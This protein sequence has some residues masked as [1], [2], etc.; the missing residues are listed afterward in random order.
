MAI[1]LVT[2][3]GA[4]RRHAR[5]RTGR[6]GRVLF[7]TDAWRPQVNG[8]VRTLSK[9]A[10]ALPALG[11]EPVFLSP[12]GFRTIPLPGYPGIRLALP[13]PSRVKRAMAEAGADHVHIVTEGPLGQLARRQ[14]LK[15]GRRF[16]SNYHTKFP[17][18]L[19]ARAPIP[20]ALTYALLRRFHNAAAATLVATQSLRD[21][22][23]AKGF[24][25]IRPWTRCVD[26]EQFRPDLRTDRGWPGPVF[27]YVGRVS[28]EKNIE[29][30]LSASLPGSKVVVGVGPALEDLKARF[31]DA[32]FLGQL[33]DS[34]L[35]QVYASSDVFVF[36]SR[37][38][39]FG[40]VLLEALASGLPVAAYPVTG[41]LDIVGDGVVGALSEDL[42]EAA[43]AALGLDRQK[44]RERAFEYSPDNCARML[45][46]EIE[47]VYS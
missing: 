4:G 33:A 37:T 11:V 7:V 34:E 18:Y 31:P 40:I 19:S 38:D 10:T 1:E 32:I 17:E 5:E 22:L 6:I 42:A 12:D 21:E 47:R 43:K 41:P 36:P 28:V 23:T 3:P 16:T 39:T 25:R 46:R 2:G 9:M 20:E 15:D 27:L 14:C 24:T 13:S 8:V 44:A 35:A 45:M 29:A 30:F 26:T